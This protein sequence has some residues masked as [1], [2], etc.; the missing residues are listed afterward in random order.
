MSSISMTII[1]IRLPFLW[2]FCVVLAMLGLSVGT[3]VYQLITSPWGEEKDSK[4]F[5]MSKDEGEKKIV[6]QNNTFDH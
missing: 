2:Y 1:F 4:L 5:Q 3:G 6:N